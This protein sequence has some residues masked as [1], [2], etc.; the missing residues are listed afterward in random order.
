MADTKLYWLHLKHCSHGKPW[1]CRQPEGFLSCGESGWTVGVLDHF[2]QGDYL[3]IGCDC[4]V[5]AEQFDRII[6]LYN[7]WS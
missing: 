1:P 7:P 5:E 6:P 3:V 2:D 4:P